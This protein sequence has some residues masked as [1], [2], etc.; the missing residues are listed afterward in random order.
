MKNKLVKILP[1]F[2]VIL[3]A[4]FLRIYQFGNVPSSMDWDEVAISYNA[5]SIAETG[6]DEY[7]HKFP[8][9]FR[10]FDDYKPPLYIYLSAPLF[11]IFGPVDNLV[12]IPALILGIFCVFGTYLLSRKL[13]KE[14]KVALA[15]SFFIAVSPWSVHFSRV[16]FEGGTLLFFVVFGSYFFLKS[17]KKRSISIL[18]SLIFFGFGLYTYHAG[19]IIIPLILSVL[20][21]NQLSELKK[22]TKLQLS[23][24]VLT[25]IIFV[26]P[27]IYGFLFSNIQARFTATNIFSSSNINPIS[28]L[29]KLRDIENNDNV[30][31]KLFHNVNYY[32]L[33]QF[34]KNYLSHFSADFLFF[35]SDNPRHHAPGVGLLLLA[36]LPLMI[37]GIYY[38]IKRNI[39]NSSKIVLFS[40]IFISPIASALTFESPHSIRSALLVLPLSMLSGLGI[41]GL[42]NKKTTKIIFVYVVISIVLFFNFYYFFHQYFFHNNL[43][44][45]PSWQQGRKEAAIFTKSNEDNYD[46][47]W[48]SNKLEQ[49]YIYWLF[50]QKINPKDYLSFG[51]TKAGDQGSDKN[52]YL[53]YSFKNIAQSSIPN[54]KKILIIG[55]KDEFSLPKLKQVCSQNNDTL[56]DIYESQP[57]SK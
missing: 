12:R 36:Q 39:P 55:L 23:V 21:I 20:V 45:A 13:F 14:E 8:L 50:Y 46:E 33:E 3:I 19:K 40:L 28:P 25:G 37:F 43:E 57:A 26:S 48:I 53:K 18:I 10:S 56:I 49:S 44:T 27:L 22:L 2:F 24:F 51:G 15:A 54:D 9:V 29:R 31:P 32:H 42:V 47:I 11:K 5:W 4:I 30:S 6:M 38:L 52:S 41:F 1:L 35:T 7:G 16:A 17:S 34:V